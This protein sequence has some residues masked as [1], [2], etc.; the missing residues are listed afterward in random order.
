[1]TRFKKSVFDL[2]LTDFFCFFCIRGIR[3][4]V[5]AW[6]ASRN[7]SLTHIWLF[8]FVF[9]VSGDTTHY[10]L[11]EIRL[12]LIFDFFF[13]FVSGGYDWL[14]S[15]DALQ[16]IRLWLI[17][18]DRVE[19]RPYLWGFYPYRLGAWA[20]CPPS[21]TFKNKKKSFFLFCQWQCPP[22]STFFLSIER[23]TLPLRILI[24]SVLVCFFFFDDSTLIDLVLCTFFSLY[25]VFCYFFSVF[26]LLLRML[27]RTH[28][29]YMRVYWFL[30]F[31]SFLLLLSMETRRRR[32][33]EIWPKLFFSHI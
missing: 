31:F 20:L 9:F 16:E 33:R 2:Y 8:F 24:D 14:P 4:S 1:M 3:L 22:S 18:D 21:P 25:C 29:I 32:S 7:L 17:F 13:V 5:L 19:E 27:Q 28:S 6:R 10:A 26:F 15:R 30:F 12:W 23:K 11:Q